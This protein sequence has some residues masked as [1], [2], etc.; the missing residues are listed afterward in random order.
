MIHLLTGDRYL[1]LAFILYYLT[2]TKYKTKQN[3]NCDFPPPQ[4]ATKNGIN[5][6]KISYLACKAFGRERHRQQVQNLFGVIF[7]G[8]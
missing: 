1:A 4:T 2:L 7:K 5:Q 6:N 8:C 3:Q